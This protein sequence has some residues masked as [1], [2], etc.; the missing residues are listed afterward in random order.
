[1]EKKPLKVNAKMFLKD[2][3]EGKSDGELM[4]LHG[5]TPQTLAKLISVLLDKELLD[6]SELKS[7][8]AEAPTEPEFFIPPP[9]PQD[10]L[11]PEPV[12]EKNRR[13]YVQSSGSSCPQCGAKH[14]PSQFE[15]CGKCG[16]RLP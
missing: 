15:F 4:R 11:P 3:R 9:R 8:R 2:F 5:L 10:I 1:M 16:G 7:R 13:E 14:L 12:H 6:P